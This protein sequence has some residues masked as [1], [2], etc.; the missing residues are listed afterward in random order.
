MKNRYFIAICLTIFFVVGAFMG[1]YMA[2]KNTS[3]SLTIPRQNKIDKIIGAI[4]TQ[5]VDEVNTDSIIESI[6]PDLLKGLD[7]HSMYISAEDM[8]AVNEDMRGNFGGIGVQFNMHNDTVMVLEVIEGGPSEKAKIQWGDRIVSVNDSKI[9]GVGMS[10]DTIMTLLRGEMGT[11]V[12]LGIKSRNKSNIK[13]VEITRGSI[14]ISS[15]DASYMVNDTIGFIK[16]N[17][18]SEITN[19]EFDMHVKQLMHQGM[20]SLIVDLRG[21]PG[22]SLGAV[23]N[24]VDQFLKK[25]ETILFTEGVHQKRET[26][27]ATKHYDFKNLSV[28]VMISSNSASASEIFAGAIQ[29]NDLGYI[30]GQRSFGKGLVQSQL[31]LPD[32]S[33][34]RITIARYYIP[35]GRCIQK[36][37]DHGKGEYSLDILHR[38]E[39][40]ELTNADSISVDSTQLF[41]TKKGRKVFG[42][43]GIMPDFFVPIDTSGSSALMD[44]VQQNAKLYKFALNYVDQNLEDIKN[45]CNENNIIGYLE[46]R[47]VFD[48]FLKNIESN[49]YKISKADMK[50]SGDI[51]KNYTYA[52]IARES[53]G[54]E[55]FYKVTSLQDETF[56]KTLKI[57]I[58]GDRP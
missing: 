38:Y 57:A 34:L 2:L 21:N 22:G 50:K 41:Y 29:D 26:A 53:F 45:N 48:K 6:I 55:A 13:E 23:I 39:H 54:D 10:S 11:K 4:K 42:G 18:F 19:L 31:M 46:K 27:K 40:G 44:S 37:Y 8:K 56:K 5:Y 30:I 36:P 17:R 49:D 7:P 43:G 20:K 28:N 58:E 14:P 9:A 3:Y 15:I 33:A 16:V 35:S 1:Y 47:K 24:I 52:Y 12:K 32:G 25:D 51:I